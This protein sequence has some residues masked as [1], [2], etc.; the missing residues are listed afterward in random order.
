MAPRAGTKMYEP[1]EAEQIMVTIGIR[2]PNVPQDVPMEKDIKV[3][4]TNTMNGSSESEMLEF[5]TKPEMNS[6]VPIISR[7]TPPRVQERIR[8]SIGGTMLPIP[9]TID[10]M[11]VLASM[12]LRGM[13]MTNA[14]TR[15]AKAPSER[16]AVG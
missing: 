4:I 16:P 11:N 10:F 7:H 2:I 8:I 6:P 1:P 15:A 12:I 9:P 13:Y 3:A 5:A 14:V